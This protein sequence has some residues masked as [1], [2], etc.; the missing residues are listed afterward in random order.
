MS[1]T[2]RLVALNGDKLDRYGYSK[3][4]DYSKE[5]FEGHQVGIIMAL[6]NKEGDVVRNFMPDIENRDE[7]IKEIIHD[8][9]IVLIGKMVYDPEVDTDNNLYAVAYPYAVEG[10]SVY[11]PTENFSELPFLTEEEMENGTKYRVQGEALFVHKG[12]NRYVTDWFDIDD[13]R[14]TITLE[15]RRTITLEEIG[16]ELQKKFWESRDENNMLVFYD[17]IGSEQKLYVLEDRDLKMLMVSLR[18][19]KIERYS[20]FNEADM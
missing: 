10:H 5:G 17:E 15:E 9:N 14:R 11:E 3:Y 18:V 12:C 8:D 6:T 1:D 13:N 20:R 4:I 19:V 7:V 2:V 16:D